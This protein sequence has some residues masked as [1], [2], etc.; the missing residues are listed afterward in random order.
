MRHIAHALPSW[1][2][3]PCDRD[4]PDGSCTLCKRDAMVEIT[5]QKWEKW[6]EKRRKGTHPSQRRDWERHIAITRAAI[7]GETLRPLGQRCN[8]SGCRAG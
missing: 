4:G 3:T 7:G 1:S 5:L 8:V 6:L 2:E